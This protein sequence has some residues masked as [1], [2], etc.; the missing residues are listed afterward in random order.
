MMATPSSVLFFLCLNDRGGAEQSM[1]ALARGMASRGRDVTL[2]VYGAHPELARDYGFDGKVINLR[3]RRSVGAAI[4]LLRLLRTRR[5]SHVISALSHTNLVAAFASLGAGVPVIV[6]EHGGE[7]LLAAAQSPVF[8]FLLRFFY[9]RAFAVVAVSHSLAAQMRTFLRDRVNIHAIY[10][11]VVADDLPKSLPAAHNWLCDT[12]IPVIMG[13]GRLVAVKNFDLALQAFAQIVKTRPARLILLGEGPERS[14][15][16][17]TA[18]DLGIT[19]HVL[20]P[21]FTAPVAAWLPYARVFVSTS[22]R[23]GLGN[24]LIE[25]L[26]AGVPVVATDCP[27]GPAEILANGTYGALVPVGDRGALVQAITDALDQDPDLGRAARQQRAQDF[28][29]STCIEAYLAL[30]EARVS[31]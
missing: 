30:V 27:Y 24:A 21:G 31:R 3:T 28:S 7:G 17:Q 16:L 29:V 2:A 13:I 25:A 12:S 6:T 10:N 14:A 5:Y 11:P 18:R 22:N 1:M 9:A 20:L 4:P 23:E 15:L 19:D 8:A 26:A